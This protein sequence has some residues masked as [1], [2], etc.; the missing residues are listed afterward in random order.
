MIHK[1][2]PLWGGEMAGRSARGLA[3]LGLDLR[4]DSNRGLVD[5]ELRAVRPKAEFW[6]MRRERPPPGAQP[7]WRQPGPPLE[8][9][10]AAIDRAASDVLLLPGRLPAP[11]EVTCRAHRDAPTGVSGE[12]AGPPP[13]GSRDAPAEP[14]GR[15]GGCEL[16]AT[17]MRRP[18]P[19]SAS[20]EASR[21]DRQTVMSNQRYRRRWH[22]SKARLPNS[23]RL[24]PPKHLLPEPL[25]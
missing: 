20:P 5:W 17:T 1:S 12:D 15:A 21:Q 6:W 25:P 13:E 3:V 9:P 19:P 4:P 14:P 16:E 24:Q 18:L 8:P 7:A 10:P 2:D 23:Y 22:R 11:T